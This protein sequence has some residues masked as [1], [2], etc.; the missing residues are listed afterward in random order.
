VAVYL[1]FYLQHFVLGNL[2]IFWTF[3][4]VFPSEIGMSL[5]AQIYKYY[6]IELSQ[7]LRWYTWAPVAI[8]VV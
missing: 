7:L 5:C 4:K 6:V 2:I 1:V 3:L 8:S